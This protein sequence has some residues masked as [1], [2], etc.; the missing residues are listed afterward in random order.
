MNLQTFTRQRLAAAFTFSH[1]QRVPHSGPTQPLCVHTADDVTLDATLLERG[2][3]NAIII[4][5]G[6]AATRRSLG[7]VWLAE[8]LADQW[9]IL[10]FDWRG[11]GTSQGCLS[12]G[13]D[14][15]LDLVAMIDHARSMGYQRVGVIGESMGGL[16]TLATLGAVVANAADAIATLGAPAD[17]T[18]TGWP[19]PFL[20]RHL[21]PRSWA[22]PIAPLLGFRMGSL[23]IAYPL[24]VIGQIRVPLLL[25]HGTKDGIVPVRNAHLLHRRAP[26]ADLRIYQGVG[27]GVEAMRLQVPQL[28]LRDLNTHFSAM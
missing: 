15:A 6:F 21:A 23:K 16:I 3:P 12:F 19:R 14:E 1:W 27:H 18:L 9:D 7:I 22:R 28:L 24:E 26:H 20:I 17:Y 13:S 10:T 11:C 8:A 4:C 5:H 25:V 2:H